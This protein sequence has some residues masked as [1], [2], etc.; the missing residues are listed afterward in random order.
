MSTSPSDHDEFTARLR[1]RLGQVGPSTTIRDVVDEDVVVEVYQVQVDEETMRRHAAVTLRNGRRYHPYLKELWTAL[2]AEARG[3]LP[4]EHHDRLIPYEWAVRPHLTPPIQK[5]DSKVTKESKRVSTANE[6]LEEAIER[7]CKFY[8]PLRAPVGSPALSAWR[9]RLH[10]GELPGD[11]ELPALPH[12]STGRLVKRIEPHGGATPQSRVL[13]LVEG[14]P[15]RE[16]PSP[17]R[18]R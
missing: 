18:R 6:E 7:F 15:R 5:A 13:Q 4:P 2:I 1:E 9:S 11:E 14:V 10:P 3:F 8:R 16:P 12:F 17:R